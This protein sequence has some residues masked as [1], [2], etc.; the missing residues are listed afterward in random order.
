[1]ARIVDLTKKWGN[2]TVFDKFSLDIPDKK[3][4]AILGKSGVGKTT[5]L[6]AVAGVI[7]YE[8]QIECGNAVSYVFQEHRLIPFMTVKENL[9]YVLTDTIKDK[10]EVNRLIE[11]VLQ[12]VRLEKYADTVADKLSGGEKQ[13]VALARALVYPSDVVLMDEPFNSLDVGLKTAVM[14]EYR[15]L[16]GKYG[17]T[18]V[19]V[20]HSVDEAL[21]FADNIVFLKPNQAVL[22]GAVDG[23]RTFGYE[24]DVT[25]RKRLYELL[26]DGAS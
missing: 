22:L 11:G 25:I 13:R 15:S 17:K 8:G 6:N 23:K 10:S 24:S 12:S 26:T 4:T 16:F 19:F 14:N 7:D 3:I 21:Y 5:L 18:C 1:M 2:K 20:T 9:E